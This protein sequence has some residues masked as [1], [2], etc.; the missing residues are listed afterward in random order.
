MPRAG[1]NP[2]RRIVGVGVYPAERLE[3]L[4]GRAMYVGSAIHKSRLADYDLHPPVNP[5][6][7]KSL[8]DKTTSVSKGEAQGLMRSGILRGMV[9]EYEDDDCP[10]YIWAVADDGRVFE[11][12]I[13]LGG[14]HGYELEKSDNMRDLVAHEWRSRD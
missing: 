11:A 14:Y 2:K 1:N 13:G 3:S 10:K 4:A 9:S 6:A 8:C 5:R 7:W 12:K